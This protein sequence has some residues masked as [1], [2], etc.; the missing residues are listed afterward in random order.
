MALILDGTSGLFGNVTG[1]DISGNFIGLN[2]NGSSLTATATGSTTAR[3]LANRFADAVNVL[4]FGA[5]PTGG[6]DSTNNIQNAINS[7]S[8][9][10]SVFFPKGTYKISASLNINAVSG[11]VSGIKLIGNGAAIIASSS[12]SSFFNIT[13]DQVT[14]SDFN[15]DSGSSNSISAVKCVIGN[16]NAAPSLKINQCTFASFQKGLELSGQLYYINDNFFLNCVNAIYFSDSGMNSTITRNHILGSTYGIN[17]KKV[18][19]QVEGTR[20]IDNSIFCTSINGSAISFDSALECYIIGNIIDQTG[21]GTIGIYGNAV[22]TNTISRIKIISNWIAGGANSYCCFF[23]N[24]TDITLIANTLVESNVQIITAGA[25]FTNI[26]VLNLTNNNSLIQN[27]SSGNDIVLVTCVNISQFANSSFRSQAGFNN[28][29]TFSNFTA[30]T[31]L[32]NKGIFGG[33]S[34][35]GGG[36]VPTGSIEPAGSIYMRTPGVVGARLYVSQGGGSWLPV[37]GV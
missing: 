19:Q 16:L 32:S 10:G 20:I 18:L 13:G 31:L 15:F 11:T 26:N 22:G 17:F 2:G 24:A 4:D 27:S 3:S 36:A 33:Q 28:S 8:L 12:L 14:I 30:P 35:T 7:A 29:T 34:I 25:A 1:G 23:A 37:A 9:F 6:V 5:D 21:N